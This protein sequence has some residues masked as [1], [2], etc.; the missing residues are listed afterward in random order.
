MIATSIFLEFIFVLRSIIL[1][2]IVL[3]CHLLFPMNQKTYVVELLDVDNTCVDSFPPFYLRINT[4]SNGTFP[5][6]IC[7]NIHKDTG[8]PFVTHSFKCYDTNKSGDI[9]KCTNNNGVT[10]F[11]P[12]CCVSPLDLK[13]RSYP[14]NEPMLLLQQHIKLQIVCDSFL[15]G[16]NGAAVQVFD[17]DGVNSIVRTH[18]S[19]PSRLN[20]SLN[21]SLATACIPLILLQ[22]L[23]ALTTLLSILIGD[24]LLFL[25]N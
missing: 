15:T 14:T 20:C 24:M 25:I 13:I 9:Q 22:A 3:F 5:R 8:F 18:G 7:G 6:L 16:S 21:Y 11:F 12:I 1:F 10:M 17:S 4:L 2:F 23:N 19:A